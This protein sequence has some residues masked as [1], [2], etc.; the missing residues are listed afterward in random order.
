[1]GEEENKKTLKNESLNDKAA[2]RWTKIKAATVTIHGKKHKIR[3]IVR[4]KA[5]ELPRMDLKD[6]DVI[7]HYENLKKAI[8]IDGVAGFNNY[9]EI[10]NRR[11]KELK[12]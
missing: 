4:A 1:M 2:T 6:G 8:S 11:I 10:V 5:N 3:K 7:N 12:Q 9:I